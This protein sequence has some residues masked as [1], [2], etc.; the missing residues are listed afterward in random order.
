MEKTKRLTLSAVLSA[1][2]VAVLYLGSLIEVLDLTAVFIASLCVAFAVVEL[3]SPWQWLT[4]LTSAVLAMLLV[5]NKFAA[6]EYAL[7]VGM[8]PILKLYVER[9][10]RALAFLAKAVIFNALY[11]AVLLLSALVFHLPIVEETVMGVTVPLP[12]VWAILYLLGNVAFF[13][14]D[15]LLT[16]LSLVYTLRW[17]ARVRKWLKH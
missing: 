1:L 8:F 17:Q 5:P 13:L 3:G 9:L 4:Y 12:A 2:A 10:P 6:C 15:Y 16:R 11:T 14:Y 7:M